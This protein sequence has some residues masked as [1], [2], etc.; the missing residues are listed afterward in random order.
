MTSVYS[1][2]FSSINAS[3][4]L[5][6]DKSLN[7]K[8]GC[9]N[10]NEMVK[11]KQ[12]RT[13]ASSVKTEVASTIRQNN[14]DILTIKRQV[15]D[16]YRQGIALQGG[17][18]Y[19]QTVVVRSSEV[20]ADKNAT[21]E[22]ILNLLQETAINH[23]RTS[24]LVGDGFGVTP[25]MLKNDL[26]WIVTKLSVEIDS[27]PTWDEVL[28][29]D[30]W[31][32]PSGKNGVQKDWTIKNLVTG[33]ILGRAT[34][35][36]MMMNGKTRRLSKIPE[37]VK[38]EISP[39]FLERKED[40]SAQ[41]KIEKLANAIYINKNLKPKRSDIDM[42][43]HVNNVKYANWMLEA[44]PETILEECQL[45]SITLEFRREC[46]ISETIQSL[47]QPD[48]NDGASK[49]KFKK[50]KSRN[51]MNGYLPSLLEDN[52]HRSFTHLLQTEGHT[53]IEEIEGPLPGSE[54]LSAGNWLSYYKST[55]PN[56]RID[57][58]SQQLFYPRRPLFRTMASDS[59]G[60]T[61]GRRTLA[62][63]ELFNGQNAIVAVNVHLGYN[64]EDSL[65]M[66]R[67]SLERGMFRSEH[68]L[69]CQGNCS[70]AHEQ[71]LHH[72]FLQDVCN[73]PFPHV[74]S[75]VCLT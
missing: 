31:L 40:E 69:Y 75:S 53:K 4:S 52:H 7:L 60:K 17:I 72:V 42:N 18:G 25:G 48:K 15:A 14:N 44:I 74:N 20:G 71:R 62:R 39:F 65:V 38:A 43:H 1:K 57:T 64:Q 41:K 50:Y 16:R 36:W 21:I 12:F 28:E 47:C 30:T 26:I 49:I 29:V 11:K 32:R 61:L 56:I 59:L 10:N 67:A 23:L 73:F 46:G 6:S 63:P 70:C 51:I 68:T 27:Y 19:K 34:S 66:N 35:K 5:A 54:A 33:Q 24:G 13:T 3:S 2:A 22:C 58:L 8:F 55:N 9:K 37:E 45:S